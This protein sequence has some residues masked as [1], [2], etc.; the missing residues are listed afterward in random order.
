M[1]DGR[2]AICRLDELD[3]LACRE[4]EFGDGDWPMAGF[5][6]RQGD[7]VH[8]YE[9][10]CPHAGHP[11]NWSPGRFLTPDRSALICASHGAMFGIDS[12]DCLAGPCNGRGLRRLGCEVRDGVVYVTDGLA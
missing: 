5:V 8:A 11:L 12:G 1:P 7:V 3:D 6:V 2:V 10:R 4:F 9:N